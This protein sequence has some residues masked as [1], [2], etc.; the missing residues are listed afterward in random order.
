MDHSG[1]LFSYF[2][3]IAIVL[4]LILA[5]GFF[6][7]SEFALVGSRRSKLSAL[8][9]KGN[10]RAARVL[11]ALDNLDAYISATQLGITLASL[12]L[13]WVGEPTVAALFEP[14]FD[15]VLSSFA[16]KAASH[17]VATAISFALIT[18]FTIVLGELVPK[19]LALQRAQP[20]AMVVVRP[21]EVFQRVFR[22]PIW[23]LNQAG[24]FVGRLMGLTTTAGHT[25][26][27]TEEEFRQLIELSN[28]GGHI[29]KSQGQMLSRALDFS[30]LTAHDA[31]IPRTEVNAISES[32][33]LEQIVAKIR[34]TEFSRLAVCKET[35]DVI[36]G[37]IH[38]KEVL[39][40]YWDD[41]TSFSLSDVLHP[42]DFIPD[43]MRLD[44]VLKRMQEERT[45][46]AVVTDEHGGVE[47]IITLEDVLEEIVGEIQD[48]F[49]DEAHQ[50]IQRQR[51]GVFMID[52]SLPVRSANRRLNLK[53]PED[54]IYHTIA[55]FLMAQT[56]RILREGE[57][58]EHA[59]ARF[60][61]ERTDRHR[62]KKVKLILKDRVK[63]G[64]TLTTT[65]S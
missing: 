51:A 64:G 28:Q 41:R 45:H 30:G 55:G 63:P 13:G 53:L 10:R 40:R 7:T 59:D 39:T 1:T 12:A 19:M 36:V 17:T 18:F 3:R 60:I 47:G 22:A 27:Y 5:N 34:E 52:G 29:T 14:L 11:K 31:M 46:F 26:V 32:M 56:G 44:D 20:V 38:S 8:A 43:N 42:V 48:E 6:V 4:L 49:D 58:V 2:W 16:A 50:L 62:I 9:A 24:S 21:M 57:V 61:V 25:G 23:V 54:A 37:V 15:R 35:M 33:S 65:A